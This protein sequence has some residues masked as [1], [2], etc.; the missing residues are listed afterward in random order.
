MKLD[1][2]R[3]RYAPLV[4]IGFLVFVLVEYAV[5]GPQAKREQAALENS[6]R[7]I[8]DPSSSKVLDFTSG[9][10]TSGGYATRILVTRV[11]R[12]EI[13]RHYRQ[14][15]QQ[16][17]LYYLRTDSI[18]G[19]NRMIFCADLNKQVTILELPESV[20]GGLYQYRLTSNWGIDY[21][22]R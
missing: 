9:F 19:K 21:G 20:A 11:S 13:G 14:E 17:G 15:L 1:W 6:L 4:A 2:K 12:E 7:S 16:H 3:L 8:S 18:L 5:R 10:K 22:C